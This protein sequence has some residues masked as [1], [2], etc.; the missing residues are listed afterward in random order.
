MENFSQFCVLQQLFANIF[1][2]ENKIVYIFKVAKVINL[3]KTI[4]E[5]PCKIL[6]GS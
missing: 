3:G 4:L 1:F 5:S 6:Q 2:Y